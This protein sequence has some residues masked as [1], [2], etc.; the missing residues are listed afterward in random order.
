MLDA[1]LAD[2]AALQKKLGAA[3]Q[4]RV[5]QHLESIR[6][7]RAAAH[8]DADRT[9][10]A[11]RCAATRPRR[12]PAKDTKS[13]APPAVNTAM[14]QLSTLALACDRTRVLTY[15]FSLPAA[16]VYYRHLAPT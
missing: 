6:G 7:H 14:A 15:M 11:D 1:V 8:D 13:E 5:E 4:Q 16:H 3:D 9:T 12:P 10:T 2:G